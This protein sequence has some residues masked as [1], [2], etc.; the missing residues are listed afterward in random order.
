MDDADYDPAISCSACEACCCRL[1]VMLMGDDEIPADLTVEDQWGGW[2][3]LRLKDGRCAALNRN[4]MKCTIYEHR[5]TVCRDYQTGASDCISERSRLLVQ[6]PQPANPLHGV[7]LEMILTELVECHGWDGMGRQIDI[8]CFN[9]EPSMAS[10]LKFL[11][12]TPWARERVESLYIGMV[13]RKTCDRG[14]DRNN[15]R[16]DTKPNKNDA[17]TTNT[18]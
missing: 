10:S 8:R 16:Q 1:E 5:P 2:V 14:I 3:M 15:N 6:K 11:R 18:E 13:Q 17:A 7:T 9:H 4:T 12:R